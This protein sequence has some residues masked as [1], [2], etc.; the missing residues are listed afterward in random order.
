MNARWIAGFFRV[1]SLLMLLV[2][3]ALLSAIL[4]M[5]FAI[6]GTEV[7]VPALKGMTV[8]AAR[9][10][11]SGLGL[12]LHVD[13]H[14]YSG[15]VTTGHILTQ[16]P[17]PGTLVRHAWTVRVAESLG[18]QTVDIPNTVGEAKRVAQLELRRAGLE[19]GT[20][21]QLPYAGAVPGT[22]IAQDPPPHAQDIERP[23]VSL[24]VAAPSDEAPDGWVMP[25]L[26]GW[27]L[28]SAEAALARVGIKTAP[29]EFTDVP[30]E[31]VG[32][33]NAPPTPPVKPGSVIAQDP[34]AGMRVEQNT[35]VRLTVA[36]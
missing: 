10:E 12:K 24:L 31:P 13:N 35:I 34:A 15:E 21:A 30:I 14:Y 16:S 9:R 11:T 28:A 5:H 23:T 8:A 36:K 33:A 22:V 3:V 32:A 19:V 20:V 29:P 1:A 18:P 27:T 6:H 2:A 7:Q 4:T 25:N 26:T 17:A